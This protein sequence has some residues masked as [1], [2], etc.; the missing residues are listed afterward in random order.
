VWPEVAV[1]CCSRP[2]ALDEC[3]ASIGDAKKLVDILVGDTQRIEVYAEKG[4]AISQE[5]PDEVR[6]AFGRLVEAGYTG[7]LVTDS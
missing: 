3:V 4:C 2:L 6:E 1:V 5:M 7:W